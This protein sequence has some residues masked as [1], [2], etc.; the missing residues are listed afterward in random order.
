M[1]LNGFVHMAQAQ[2]YGFGLLSS[3]EGF[4]QALKMLWQNTSARVNHTDTN[5]NRG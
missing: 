3:E 2:T 5:F 4:Q 1:L